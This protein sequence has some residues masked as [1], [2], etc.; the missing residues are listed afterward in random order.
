M[1]LFASTGNVVIGVFH[2]LSAG[3]AGQFVPGKTGATIRADAVEPEGRGRVLACDVTGA[4]TRASPAITIDAPAIPTRRNR[5][6][7]T[8]LSIY[9]VYF[10]FTWS[11]ARL[12]K[13]CS[14]IEDTDIVLRRMTTRAFVEWIDVALRSRDLRLR[15][16]P[17]R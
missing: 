6:P 16:G 15:R 11:R 5:G 8:F 4:A 1:A 7:R 10:E 13:S 14:T 2:T 9:P 17:R 3:K 12:S